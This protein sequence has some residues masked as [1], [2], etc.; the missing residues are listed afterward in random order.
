MLL[1]YILSALLVCGE[2]VG[3]VLFVRLFV[4]SR[5][6]VLFVPVFVLYV[7]V[8]LFALHVIFADNVTCT[9]CW[10]R[11][12]ADCNTGIAQ[13]PRPPPPCL[14]RWCFPVDENLTACCPHF[15]C[16]AAVCLFFFLSFFDDR[17]RLDP[18][19]ASAK[20]WVEMLLAV[21]GWPASVIDFIKLC[22][23]PVD[24][25]RELVTSALLFVRA[26]LLGDVCIEISREKLHNDDRLTLRRICKLTREEPV[27]P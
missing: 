20:K 9:Y 11:R 2:K 6:P 14:L 22:M 17:N 5:V 3:N 23:A 15:A 26:L 16:D 13:T 21:S 10:S 24:E 1:I 8:M 19:L 18:S 25:V 27:T 7:L 12:T 4:L